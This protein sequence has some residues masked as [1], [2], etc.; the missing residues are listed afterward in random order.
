MPDYIQHNPNI[1]TGI[2]GFT[3][4]M[5]N[6]PTQGFKVNIVRIFEDGEYV[7]T[8]S[9]YDFFGKK[10]GFGIFRFENGKV[11]EHWDNLTPVQPKTRVVE[12]NLMER[13]L[14]QISLKQNRNKA[15]IRKFA[16]DILIN[17]KMDKIANY[18]TPDFHQHNPNIADGIKGLGEIN[19]NYLGIIR[20]KLVFMKMLQQ[21]DEAAIINTTSAV[22]SV[23]I[24]FISTYSSKAALQSYTVSL[25]QQLKSINSKIKFSNS[26]RQ[27]LIPK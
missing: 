15:I 6:R 26:Y 9:E 16:D 8:H 3:Q 14:L 27:L 18:Q 22:A 23:P 20:L 19:T 25:R 24:T 12:H 2:A 21:K 10:S 1:E 17:G 7:I 5:K 13:K 11:A 4:V